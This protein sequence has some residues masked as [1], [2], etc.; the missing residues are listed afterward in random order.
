M[1]R[2]TV[3]GEQIADGTVSLTADVKDVLPI[4]NGGTN[5][6]TASAARTALGLA[7]GTDVQAYD[8]DLAA[9]AGLS[10]ANDD[11]VQRKAG[12]WTNRTMDQLKA[13]LGLAV[14]T[15]R[16]LRW[17]NGGQGNIGSLAAVTA[18]SFRL[19]MVLPVVTTRWRLLLS[20]YDT[21]AATSKTAMTLK[22]LIYG[23]HSRSLT[24]P[25]AETGDFVGSAATTLVST[26]Q[27]I[28]GDGTQYAT[29]WVSTAGADQFSPYV[30]KLIGIGITCSSQTVQYSAGRCWRWTNSTSATTAA[31]AAS[32]A[33]STAS[34][35]PLDVILEYE[36]TSAMP[37]WL[38]IGDSIFEGVAA[39]RAAALSPTSIIR[40]PVNQWARNNGILVQN[41]ALYAL[42]AVTLENAARREWTRQPQTGGAFDGAIIELGT[43]DVAN[44]RT[45]AQIQTSIMSIVDTVR[46]T[47]GTDKPIH[48][49]TVPAHG[50]S[51]GIETVRLNVNDWYSQL[52]YGVRGT[53]DIDTT[54][55]K[56]AASN[57]S[58]GTLMSSDGVHPS[59]QGQAALAAML[60]ASVRERP[61]VLV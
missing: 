49:C 5:G 12:A 15:F 42:Q 38:V 26:D 11:I 51:G 18:M 53:C 40:S 30:E 8:A 24:S 25:G 1:A 61:S 43:N 37:A 22:A 33:T 31:T 44:S 20:N 56:T 39:A 35:V 28:P 23:D 19:A 14:P 45:L 10:P 2:T 17:S 41:Q 50:Q 48:L 7:I 58:D 52:P 57:I 47:I 55:R 32:G 16:T 60:R 46:D 6:S 27:T 29:P 4:A 54:L 3:R 13:D 59:Y 34:Y 21:F 9:V 36:C